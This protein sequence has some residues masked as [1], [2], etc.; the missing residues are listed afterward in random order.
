[1]TLVGAASVS[2]ACARSSTCSEPRADGSWPA[3][4][5]TSCPPLD[6]ARDAH[7]AP[8]GD[9][10]GR[11]E[12][13]PAQLVRSPC[14]GAPSRPPVLPGAGAVLGDRVALVCLSAQVLFGKPALRFGAGLL[15]EHSERPSALYVLRS[16]GDWRAGSGQVVRAS[17]LNRRHRWGERPTLSGAAR[18]AALGRPRPTPFARGGPAPLGRP[19]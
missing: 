2:G 4:A 14:G 7:S 9:R 10:A 17:T 15:A 8:G 12:G 6:G 18:T 5:P 1:M 3:E 11:A 19:R 16:R 13:R